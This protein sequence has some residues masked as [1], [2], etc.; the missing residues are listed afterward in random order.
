VDA[1]CDVVTDDTQL[2]AGRQLY[3]CWAYCITYIAYLH[4]S[5]CAN[6]LITGHGEGD[7]RAT[8][9]AQAIPQI[10]VLGLNRFGGAADHQKNTV[11]GY[12]HNSSKFNLAICALGQA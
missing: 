8:G 4:V 6:C 11:W 12:C 5:C 9:R 2:L 3:L 7:A 1:I 10:L